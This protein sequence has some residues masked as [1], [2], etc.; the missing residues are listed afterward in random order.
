MTARSPATGQPR[1][2]RRDDFVDAVG[3]LTPEVV[4][5]P[6][7]RE[8]LGRRRAD[9]WPEPRIDGGSIVAVVRPGGGRGVEQVGGHVV[10]SSFIA[11]A[12]TAR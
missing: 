3:L 9:R 2:G 7:G 4:S 6:P 10:T 12:T 8:A 5:Q 1:S 11:R